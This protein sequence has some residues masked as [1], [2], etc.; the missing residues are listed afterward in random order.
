MSNSLRNWILVGIVA[1]SAAMHWPH[2]G[3]ELMSIHFWRQTQT[4]STAISFYEEDMNILNPRRND[5]GASE[6]LFRMEFP[7]IQ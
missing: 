7:L 3:K 6:G 1:L 4:Q 5:R 2:F